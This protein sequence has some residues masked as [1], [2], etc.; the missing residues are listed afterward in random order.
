MPRVQY[1]PAARKLRPDL[2]RDIATHVSFPFC[3]WHWQF[4]MKI[5][6]TGAVRRSKVVKK[7]RFL[8]K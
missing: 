8:R 3:I 2:T 4:V 6:E 7:G 5:P 1:G